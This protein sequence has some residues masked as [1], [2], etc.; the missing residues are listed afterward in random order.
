MASS[1]ADDVLW[2][3]EYLKALRATVSLAIDVVVR[4][5][6]CSLST[7]VVTRLELALRRRTSFLSSLLSL[8]AMCVH[9]FAGIR[10]SG[11]DGVSSSLAGDSAGYYSRVHAEGQACVSALR[12]GLVALRVADGHGHQLSADRRS[13]LTYL[14]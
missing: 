7:F 4:C 14:S 6:H 8:G 10:S 3:A 12:A 2:S 1:K 9:L 5:G 11:V 13:D